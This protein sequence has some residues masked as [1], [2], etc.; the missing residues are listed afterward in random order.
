VTPISEQQ[1][2]YYYSGCLNKAFAGEES[3]RAQ[4]AV[5]EQAFA[6]DKVMIEAQ[7]RVIARTAEPR[8]L[9]TSSDHA[10]N[11]FRQ[12]MD[13]LIA[14]EQRPAKAVAAE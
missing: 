6:E 10:L 12:L 1:T 3:S 5:F 7:A 13:G 9:G 4:I 2:V 14:L 11:Q 8:M